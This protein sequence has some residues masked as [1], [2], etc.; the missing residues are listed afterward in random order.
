MK[1]AETART[2]TCDDEK[3]APGEEATAAEEDDDDDDMVAKMATAWKRAPEEGSGRTGRARWKQSGFALRVKRLLNGL[4]LEQ[5]VCG[6]L[7]GA[8]RE[9]Q[10]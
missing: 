9:T 3:Q 6:N 5:H 10:T 1:A 4:C 2:A 8:S 7:C